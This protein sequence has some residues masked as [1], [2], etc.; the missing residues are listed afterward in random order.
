MAAMASVYGV[1][2]HFQALLRPLVRRLAGVGVRA[3]QVTVA[4]MVL[5]L[6]VGVV[7]GLWAP[8][9]RMLWLLL[10]L[11]LLV[12]MALNAIDGMLAREHGQASPLGAL[13]NELGDVL[14]DAALYLPLA[15]TPLFSLWPVSVFVLLAVLTEMTG[16]IAVQ[17]GASR[18]YDG[19][20][21]KSDRALVIGLLGFL[22]A[23]GLPA[24]AWGNA[25]I[26][27]L[28]LLC[29]WTICK[30]ARAALR[31]LAA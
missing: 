1:K 26:W 18:R 21:G 20:L 27:L 28:A 13:L 8:S 12:R 22:L 17:M 30:R 7:V 29:M 16:V 5:S 23:L 14:A 4:A 24:R 11:W 19:P 10:P 15:L 31:E 6:P 2:P 25:L 3:N 9:Q